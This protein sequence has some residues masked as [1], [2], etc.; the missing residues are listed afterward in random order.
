MIK[1]PGAIKLVS[2]KLEKLKS[3]PDY[4]SMIDFLC[5]SGLSSAPETHQYFSSAMCDVKNKL[6]SSLYLFRQNIIAGRED[7]CLSAIIEAMGHACVPYDQWVVM[8]ECFFGLNKLDQHHRAQTCSFMAYSIA[9][10]LDDEALR[11]RSQF[12]ILQSTRMTGN[13][14]IRIEY[15][16][17]YQHLINGTLKYVETNQCLVPLHAAGHLMDIGCDDKMIRSYLSASDEYL[18]YEFASL[19]NKLNWARYN[20]LSG[21]TQQ[22]RNQIN[23]LTEEFNLSI[24]DAPVIRS[25]HSLQ[26]ELGINL[27]IPRQDQKIQASK[28]RWQQFDL[29][30]DNFRYLAAGMELQRSNKRR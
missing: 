21:R 29:A 13:A 17:E 15:L 7:I 4:V 23:E 12:A 11:Q 18:L 26:N 2:E 25:L 27:S 14:D 28:R 16:R 20:F 24:I 8:K 5:I 3:D 19:N 30:L 10:Q 9:E 1:T 6:C 22:A